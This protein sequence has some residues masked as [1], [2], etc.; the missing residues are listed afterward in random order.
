MQAGESG[1][2]APKRLYGKTI[3]ELELLGKGYRESYTK[4]I[5]EE[6]IMLFASLS[7]DAQ[8]VHVDKAYAEKTRFKGV[9]AHGLLTASLISAVLGT[10]LPGPGTLLVNTNLNYLKPVFPGET[11]TATVE[12]FDFDFTRK[13]VILLARCRNQDGVLV[14]SGSVIVK[15]PIKIE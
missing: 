2:N 6:D 7:G 14:I 4:Q 15:P 12:I 8:P 10:K 1:T 13:R 11:I 3:E 5:T 9:I